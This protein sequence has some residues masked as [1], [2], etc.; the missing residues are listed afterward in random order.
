LIRRI[1]KVWS[2]LKS[3]YKYWVEYELINY[4]LIIFFFLLGL[5]ATILI[6]IIDF[7]DP[8]FNWHDIIVEAHGLIFDLFVFGLFLTIFEFFRAKKEKIKRYQKEIEDLIQIKSEESRVRIISNINHLYD[9]GIN[10]FYL[11]GAYLKNGNLQEFN[12]SNSKMLFMNFE[13]GSFL[14]SNLTNVDLRVSNLKKVSFTDASLVGANLSQSDC[15]GARFI[16][17]DLTNCDLS[18]T[19]LRKCR[20]VG[21][22]YSNSDFTEAKLSNVLV[23]DLDWFSKLED[24][25][26]KG[27]DKLKS[28][29]IVD[30]NSG[31]NSQGVLLYQIRKKKK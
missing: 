19:D 7:N 15:R 31:D 25:N 29:F 6:M 3:N 17:T 30:P 5:A 18:K 1:K 12:L 27:I 2:N 21:C 4:S 24:H 20:F 22:N 14:R 26:V 28:R 8:D 16:I 13:K 11:F 23:D 10:T 9:L